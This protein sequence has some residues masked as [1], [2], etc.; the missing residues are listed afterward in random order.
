MPLSLQD[1]TALERQE[2]LWLDPDWN[3][4]WGYGEPSQ[5]RR[6][7]MLDY[8]GDMSRYQRMLDNAGVKFDISSLAGA[9]KAEIE[10]TVRL[11]IAKR[12]EDG[13]HG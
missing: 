5:E 13:A 9:T 7:T 11:L 2:R 10:R 6:D 4:V 12:Q 1:Q 8:A 3:S